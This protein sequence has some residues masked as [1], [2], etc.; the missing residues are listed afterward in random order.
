MCVQKD[1]PVKTGKKYR[2]TILFSLCVLNRYLEHRFL[3]CVF[4]SKKRQEGV[5]CAEM[6]CYK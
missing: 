4:F 5:M 2:P 3:T 6:L 1:L